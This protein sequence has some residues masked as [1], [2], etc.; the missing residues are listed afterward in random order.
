MFQ[1]E[2]CKKN[3][4]SYQSLWNHKNIKHKHEILD[5]NNI[6]CSYCN[7]KFSRI[8]NLTRHFKICKVKEEF[9]KKNEN[10]EKKISKLE[11]EIRQLKNNP[12]PINIPTDIILNNSANPNNN[13]ENNID[14][15][16][17]NNSQNNTQNTISNNNN[18]SNSNNVNYID[19][20]KIKIVKIGCE[21]LS[22][23]NEQEINTI[24][25]SEI[26]SSIKMI[27]YVN[28]N[29]RLPENHNS[30]S[31][32]LESPYL[33]ILNTETNTIEKERKKYFFEELF[34]NSIK[35]QESLLNS[36]KN[37][38]SV[39]KIHKIKENINNLKKI[40]SS[41]FNSKIMQEIIRKINLLSYNKRNMIAET[42]KNRSDNHN[43]VDEPT[44]FF[45]DLITN[46]PETPQIIQTIE[47]ET[48]PEKP[49]PKP[50]RKPI[51]RKTPKITIQHDNIENVS[52]NNKI[53]NLVNSDDEEEIIV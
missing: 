8:D 39:S 10:Y 1:C 33:S 21:N 46:N 51:I 41:G 20:K 53:I 44:D 19:N 42:W 11:K 3:Y 9:D 24:F 17:Q 25:D 5:K 13:T 36:L 35:R 50:K 29:A 30:C 47:K 7:S 23:L 6:L 15:N 18:N 32:S 52:I 48:P 45:T 38:F 26:E 49:K 4:S 16:S 28:F 31:P 37:K 27:E 40:Q 12:S 34:T 14:N 43:D 2:Y 22:K